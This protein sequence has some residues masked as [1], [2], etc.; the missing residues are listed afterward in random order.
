MGDFARFPLRIQHKTF[1]LTPVSP[2]TC[3]ILLGKK[4]AKCENPACRILGRHAYP[5]EP[6][7]YK[8]DQIMQLLI[9]ELITLEGGK[10]L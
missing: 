4:P 2:L 10:W 8:F 7:H 1:I 3:G 6:T 5:G 9:D